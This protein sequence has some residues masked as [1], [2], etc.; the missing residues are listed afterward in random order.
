[1]ASR[2]GALC[3]LF[4]GS[5][6]Y[7]D[8]LDSEEKIATNILAERLRRLETHGIVEKRPNEED[9]RRI[10]YR[11]TAKGI[12]LAPVLI[13]I[14]VWAARYEDTAAPPTV[15]REMTQNRDGFIAN[16]R[17]RWKAGRK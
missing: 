7:R 12:D 11:L 10:D 8:F 15:I 9:A 1:M 4:M 3:G 17:Q 2:K 16:L 14:I 13:E 5:I 6:A